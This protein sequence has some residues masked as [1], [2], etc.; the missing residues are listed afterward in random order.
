MKYINEATGANLQIDG[1]G[2]CNPDNGKYIVFGLNEI[3]ESKGVEV[4][5]LSTL[6]S[7][8]YRIKTVGDD[9]YVGFT[10]RARRRRRLWLYCAKFSVSISSQTICIYSRKTVK[11]FRK[12]I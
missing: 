5:A 9:V 10:R 8:G 6:G 1:S 2:T 3:L 12:W 4:P 11:F 7:A